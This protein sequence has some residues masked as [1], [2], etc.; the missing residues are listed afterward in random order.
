M[1]LAKSYT[2]IQASASNAANS[3]TTSSS[4]QINYGISIIA[5]ITNGVT[6]PT[7]ACSV[8]CQVSPDNTTWFTYDTRTAGVTSSIDYSFSFNLGVG[9]VGGDWLYAR[10]QFTGNTGQAVTVQADASTSTNL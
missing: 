4:I 3:T 2:Q 8:I 5:Q 7:V 10:V 1:S 9:G 6:P